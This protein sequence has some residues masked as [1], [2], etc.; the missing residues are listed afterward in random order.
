MDRERNIWLKIE[1]LPRYNPVPYGRNIME[2][3]GDG[4]ISPQ[5]IERRRV[6]ALIYRE[7]TEDWRETV[8][9]KIIERDITEPPPAARIPGAV[10]YAE[11]GEL[12]RIHVFNDDNQPRSFHVHGVEYGIDS[13]GSWPFGVDVEGGRRHN[14]NR[15]DAI[16]PQ[17][18]WTYTFRITKDSVGAWP[19]HDHVTHI[20][21][22]IERGLFGGLIVRDLQA[23]S[24]D[25]EAVIFFHTLL[26]RRAQNASE[27]AFSFRS[28]DFGVGGEFRHRFPSG[29]SSP[30]RISY[31]CTRHPEM[32]GSITLDPASSVLEKR[33]DMRD[34]G[35]TGFF[36]PAHINVAPGATV[37]WHNRGGT[38]HGAMS[39]SVTSAGTVAD[40]DPIP[41]Y[42][43]NGRTFLPNTPRIVVKQGEKIRWY[44]LN[45]DVDMMWHN[46]HT[47]A[48]RWDV[49]KETVDVR[50]LG[51]AESFV[52]VTQAPPV[53]LGKPKPRNGVGE[54][55]FHCHV[56]MHMH[57][58]LVASLLVAED[59]ERV[60]ELLKG[61]PST[62]G[63]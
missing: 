41:S 29:L 9:R 60:H 53:S 20:Q 61:D 25:H 28:E 46:F 35:M 24:V 33:V 26:H 10:L 22:N 7:Y 32:T 15:S 14:L 19:F 47:H 34:L 1:R 23:S 50:S 37:I 45:L 11:P 13:D 57:M 62:V 21:E 51:P 36:D 58:G 48:Q 52:L 40:P 12:L 44:V 55:I 39:T 17:D 63:F 2:H 5:L 54:F 8:D 16:K 6:D 59:D 38:T 42:C 56:E 43:F 4:T 30:V 31:R 27:G 18:S 49:A 3:H